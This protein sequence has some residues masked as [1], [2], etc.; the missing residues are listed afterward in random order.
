MCFFAKQL[1]VG[2]NNEM[3]TKIEIYDLLFF[4]SIYRK[5]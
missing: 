4:Q 2:D 1:S 3:K 5:S